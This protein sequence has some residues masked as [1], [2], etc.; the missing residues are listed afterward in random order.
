ML[1][2]ACADPLVRLDIIDIPPNVHPIC[3]YIAIYQSNI[4]TRLKKHQCVFR[5]NVNCK[6]KEQ[7][8]K[9]KLFNTA[10]H[11]YVFSLNWWNMRVFM[12]IICQ[13]GNKLWSSETLPEW[14]SCN[15]QG[16]NRSLP[17]SRLFWTPV[18]GSWEVAR[19]V[20]SAHE[21]LRTW[22][23][24]ALSSCMELY[25]VWSRD[26]VAFPCTFRNY[27]VW[28]G[29]FIRK[30]RGIKFWS[31]HQTGAADGVA[32][33]QC[34]WGL[35]KFKRGENVETG[36]GGG[37]VLPAPAWEWAQNSMV[38]GEENNTLGFWK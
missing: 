32:S 15:R 14:V 33:Q 6:R 17:W 8:W 34:S 20:M 4:L 37:G 31:R 12:Y 13:N 1:P 30:K 11:K 7:I 23:K 28:E 18:K 35:R 22:M 21:V 5:S 25:C 26:S 24:W 19:K 27:G 38:L 9:Q 3:K 10:K 29:A 36:R 16:K 2:P